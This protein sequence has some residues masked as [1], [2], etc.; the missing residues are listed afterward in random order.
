MTVT[1]KDIRAWGIENGHKC[2]TGNLGQ[3]VVV[4]YAA[5]HPDAVIADLPDTNDLALAAVEAEAEVDEGPAFTCEVIIEG[6]EE[7]ALA[8]E[9]HIV[10]ALYAAFEAGRAAERSDMLKHLGGTA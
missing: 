6:H 7:A 5:A 9:G 2:R 4:A 8:I 3:A 10:E 1:Y